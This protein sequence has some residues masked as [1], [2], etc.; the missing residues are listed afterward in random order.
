VEKVTA[1]SADL[2]AEIDGGSLASTY[3]FEYLALSAYKANVE[4]GKEPFAGARKA[5]LS[6][7]AVV[8]GVL[9]QHVS[10]LTPETTYRFRVQ[11]TNVEG[12]TL[13]P[14]RSLGTEAPTNVFSLLDGRGWEMVSPADKQGGAIQAAEAIFGGGVFQAAANGQSLT[15]SSADSFGDGAQGS[16]AGSQYIATRI[17]SGWG[18]QNITTALFAGSYGQHPDGVPYQLFSADLSAGLLSNGQRCRTEPGECPVANLPLPG[19]GAAAGYRDYYLRDGS[20]GFDSLVTAADL[21]YTD[22]G[23]EQFEVTLVGATPDLSH[24]VLSSCA[25]LSAN[26]TEVAGPG[27]CAGQNLYM[28]SGSGL[29]LVNVLPGDTE[30]TPGAALPAQAGAISLDGGRVYF[31]ALA[32][33]VLYLREGAETKLLPETTGGEAAFQLASTDGRFAF[34]TKAAH[35]YRYDATSQASVDLTPTGEVQGV[36][37]A[38]SDGSRVYYATSTGLFLW[39]AGTTSQI[40][41]DA[42]PANYSPS[43]STG[44]AR[45]SADGS[46]LLFVSKQELTGYESN[47]LTEVFLYSA[48]STGGAPELSC[49]SCNP[50]GER[51]HAGAAIPG[52][53]ANGGSQGAIRIYR[54]RTLSANGRRAFFESGDSL[55]PQ[56]SNE[57]TDVYEWEAAGEGTCVRESGCVQLIS[58]GRAAEDSHFIDASLNGSDSF[59]LTDASI[60]PQDPG[61]YDIYDAR[62]GGGLP[63]PENTIPCEGDAC[64]ALP[65]APEDPT[66]GTLVKGPGN[67]PTR[68]AKP[69][70]AKQIGGHHKGKRQKHHKR[71]KKHSRDSGGAKK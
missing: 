49:I 28:W 66:P 61:S 11:A 42:D 39:D 58:S 67:P 45:V 10:A 31:R 59:F 1:T 36:L 22:L 26:A 41:S 23:S 3:R 48:S 14:E 16:P 60:V 21:F 69:P 30:G 29:T 7:G 44:V 54:P 52:A 27:G 68:F 33:G 6:G 47:G 34:F 55:S 5:P 70:G 18:S 63:E 17:A 13:G 2:K 4:A 32:D 65:E 20:G 19:S 62:V 43:S 35:L 9:S 57:A 38:S 8:A 64:Q 50:T 51:P 56:D 37:G 15:Y 40:A 24:V 53:I 46:H 25:A 71:H 12:T